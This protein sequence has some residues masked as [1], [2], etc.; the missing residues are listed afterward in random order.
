[1][2]KKSVKGPGAK[3]KAGIHPLQANVFQNDALAKDF[4]QSPKTFAKK[5][6][7][8]LE[9]LVCPPEAHAALK[10]GQAFAKEVETKKIKLD[11][12]SIHELRKIASA[13]FGRDYDV[14]FIPFGLQ[15]RERM[16]I[17]ANIDWTATGTATVTWLDTDAD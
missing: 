13:Q 9:S 2:K 6:G 12:E 8:P 17:D 15:F 14:S 1:M 4:L 5:L 11:E 3:S 10:R 16:K 7:I